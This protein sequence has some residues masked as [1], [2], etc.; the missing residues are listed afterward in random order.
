MTG[1]DQLIIEVLGGMANVRNILVI[2]DEAHHAWRKN[3][4]RKEKM[5][6][7]DKEAKREATIWIGELD[8][9]HKLRYTSYVPTWYTIK[10]CWIMRHSHISHCVFDSTWEATES[11][12]LET[13]GQETQRDV[14]K[15]KA[16]V[17]WVKVVNGLGEYGE[18]CCDISN[19]FADIDGIVARWLS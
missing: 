16:L 12:M 19:S 7:L 18:C 13:K 15:H 3:P 10:P 6:G 8:R 14:E 9:I 4:D 5:I 17:E 1:I 11:F 2:N